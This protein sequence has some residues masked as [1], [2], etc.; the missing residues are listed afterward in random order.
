MITTTINEFKKELLERNGSLDQFTKIST[1]EKNIEIELDLRHT[2]HS[3]ERQGRSSDYI[4]NSEI[5]ETVDLAT[6][7]LVNALLKDWVDIKE[8][9]WI[10]NETNTLNVVGSLSY[11][12]KENNKYTFKVIT[13]MKHPEFKNGH[14]SYKIVVK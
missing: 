9:V 13:V 7:Q 8:P 4:K 1:L 2:A 11:N 12:G 3:L 6:E 5:K 10:Y 14:K